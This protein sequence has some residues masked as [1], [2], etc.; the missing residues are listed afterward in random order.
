MSNIDPSRLNMEGPRRCIHIIDHV[1]I[2]ELSPTSC[3][4]DVFVEHNHRV[5]DTFLGKNPFGPLIFKIV[6][7]PVNQWEHITEVV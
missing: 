3:F 6:A 1:L 2:I 5:N 4:V 7:L